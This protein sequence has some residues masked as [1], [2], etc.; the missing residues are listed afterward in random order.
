MGALYF[1]VW[2]ETTSFVVPVLSQRLTQRTHLPTHGCQSTR[3][4]LQDISLSVSTYQHLHTSCGVLTRLGWWWGA[5]GPQW[6]VRRAHRGS[7]ADGHGA[8]ETV[9]D[10]TRSFP[11]LMTDDDCSSSLLL[12]LLYFI[13]LEHFFFNEMSL[14]TV[15]LYCCSL[16]RSLTRVLGVTYGN[17]TP[18]SVKK[19]KKVR[20]NNSQQSFASFSDLPL[21]MLVLMHERLRQATENPVQPCSDTEA[22][23]Q[24]EMPLRFK[25]TGLGGER[26]C[27]LPECI[28]K[29]L[30]MLRLETQGSHTRR[31]T[32]ANAKVVR[33]AGGLFYCSYNLKVRNSLTPAEWQW[34]APEWRVS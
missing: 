24:N 28:R 8:V 13:L 7:R 27:R 31:N 10:L 22:D 33:T 5:I 25:W 30:A 32:C 11:S 29:G 17:Q 6:G 2:L 26:W 3:G 23:A 12:Y 16:Y 14:C 1:G 9:S 21:P 20:P 19:K 15:S 4:W 18:N 34:A